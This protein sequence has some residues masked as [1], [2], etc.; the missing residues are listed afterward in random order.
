MTEVGAIYVAT[1]PASGNVLHDS[2]RITFAP[3]D[4][5]GEITSSGGQHEVYDDPSV[6]ERVICEALA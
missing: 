6:V 4:E 2:G 5:F 1:T 3:G